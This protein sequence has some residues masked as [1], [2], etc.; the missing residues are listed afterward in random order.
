MNEL[1]NALVVIC[2][3]HG[4]MVGV[5]QYY[6]PPH[7]ER[8]ALGVEVRKATAIYR[9]GAVCVM[10]DAT[11]FKTVA[12]VPVDGDYMYAKVQREMPLKREDLLPVTTRKQASR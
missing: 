8:N 9:N 10:E 6:N 1:F 4:Q 5:S 12:Y 3:L 7:L 2:S 11:D